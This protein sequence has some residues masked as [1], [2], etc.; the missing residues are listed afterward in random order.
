VTTSSGL[1][2]PFQYATRG[3]MLHRLSELEQATAM[4]RRDRELEDH[5]AFPWKDWT[6]TLTQQN[7]VTWDAATATARYVELGYATHFVC[8]L[9]V[10]SAGVAGQVVTVSLP[11]EAA[12]SA[13]A[14]AGH[15]YISDASAA[16]NHGGGPYLMSTTTV[17]LHPIVS[18]GV[19][20]GAMGAVGF[21]AA[22]AAG[23]T[24]LIAGTYERS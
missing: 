10:T 15:G 4:E 20:F 7:T 24:V 2:L 8:Q 12:Y 21:V 22:L 17:A 3:S 1:A 13:L 9:P 16:L 6:P 18:G 14:I 23:D 11:V 5:L 19:G